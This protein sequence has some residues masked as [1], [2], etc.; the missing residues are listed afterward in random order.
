MPGSPGSPFGPCKPV[1][2]KWPVSSLITIF[3]LLG[4]ALTK[5]MYPL[6]IE[7]SVLASCEIPPTN[8]RKLS[9]VIPGVTIYVVVLPLP[10]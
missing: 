6:A 10:V 7:K 3:K 2:T 1:P 4:G 5:V 8:T 9:A